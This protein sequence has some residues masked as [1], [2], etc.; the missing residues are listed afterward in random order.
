MS[1]SS[2]VL[3]AQKNGADYGADVNSALDALKTL[4]SGP[5]APSAPSAY[6]LWADTTTGMLKQRNAANTA[7]IR[8]AALAGLLPDGE[9]V[10]LQISVA[11]GALTQC[12]VTAESLSI[13]GTLVQNVSATLSTA[14]GLGVAGGLGAG[15]GSWAGNSWYTI[16]AITN[17]DGSL[18]SVQARSPGA[19][20][21]NPP[22]GYTRLRTVGYVLTKTS[23]TTDFHSFR[24]MGPTVVWTGTSA[25]HIALPTASSPATSYTDVALGGHVPPGTRLV[26]LVAQLFS[27]GTIS[28]STGSGQFLRLRENGVSIEG[29]D[30]G[31]VLAANQVSMRPV[32]M[33]C[34]AGGTIEYRVVLNGGWANTDLNVGLTVAGWTYQRVA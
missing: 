4:H 32:R 21:T 8:V 7:W 5:T 28:G 26:D 34:D 12:V 22:A 25:D 16:D 11:E 20:W 19:S 14:N 30:V 23:P 27:D 13:G 1:Q 18:F 31:F 17:E 10:G 24:Q 6:M 2:L 3:D 9:S 15:A 33:T 29:P